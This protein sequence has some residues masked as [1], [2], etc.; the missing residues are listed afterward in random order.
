M[1]PQQINEQIAS[2]KQIEK[3]ESVI[4]TISASCIEIVSHPELY[5]TLNKHFKDQSDKQR[6]NR[7][8]G[9]ITTRSNDKNKEFKIEN[10]HLT[11]QS[12]T[13][14]ST[15][16]VDFAVFSNDERI[17]IG[18]AVNFSG[19]NTKSVGMN[20]I[21]HLKKL[22]QNYNYSTHS[23]LIFLVYYEG[24]TDKFHSSYDNYLKHFVRSTGLVIYP[25]K[26]IN[27]ITKNFVKNSTSIKL[28]KSLHSYSGNDAN[29]FSI[30]HF[31]IDFSEK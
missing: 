16:T 5:R 7:R 20:I 9:L 8:T 23:D 19:Q 21:K 3:I 12:E 17:T 30:Y 26:T 25:A 6:E 31:Y 11:G 24:V 15:G 4:K 10:Q 22:T 27:N 18:E 13:K 29:E 14:N 2:P 28:A 1:S